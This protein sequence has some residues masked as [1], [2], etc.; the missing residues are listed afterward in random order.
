MS[1]T[2]GPIKVPITAPVTNLGV[3][4][5]NGVEC[6]Q[7]SLAISSTDNHAHDGIT[8]TPPANCYVNPSNVNVPA[9][10]NVQAN[11]YIPTTINGPQSVIASAM[12]YENKALP[13]QS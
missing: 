4:T 5:Y 11:A 10:G 3:T 13:V 2:G 9:A 1:D 8:L 6:N 12:G 7:Y